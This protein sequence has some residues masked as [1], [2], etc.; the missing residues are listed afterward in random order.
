MTASRDGTTR[1]WKQTATVPPAYD[2][3]ESSHSATFKTCLAYAPPFKGYPDGLIISGGQDTLIEARQPGSTADQNADGLLV[4]HSNQVC[5][6]DVNAVAGWI[7]S[8][9]WDST[10]RIW[11]IN[12]WELDVELLGHRATVWAVVAY[13]NDMVVTG[14]ADHAIRVFDRRGKLFYNFNGKQVVRALVKL[15]KGHETGGELASASNDGHIRIW[16]LRGNQLAQLSGHESFIYSL[17][18]LPAGEIVSCGEDRSV[19]IWKGTDCAQVITLPAISIWSVSACPNGDIITGSSDKVARIFTR[20][21]S[22]LADASVISE[23]DAAVKSSVIPEQQL[24]EINKTDA[25]GPDFLQQK[26]GTK[27]GQTVMIKENDGSINAY[28]WSVSQQTW[29]LVGQVVS[30]SAAS[31]GQ[32][33]IYNGKEYDYVFNINISDERPDLK[34]PYNVTQNP[35]EVAMKFLTDNELPMTYLEETANFIVKNSEGATLGQAAQRHDTGPDPWGT[36]SRYRPGGGNVSSYQPPAPH[37]A[38]AKKLPQKEYVSI[39]GGKPEACHRQ[40][41]KLNEQYVAA[42]DPEFALLQSDLDTL[43]KLFQQFVGYRFDAAAAL[44]NAPSLQAGIPIAVRIATKWQPPS[45]RLAGIDLL[46]FLAATATQLPDVEA[47]GKDLVATIATSSIFETDTLASN[48]KLAM[49]AIRFF[50]NLFYGSAS[51]RRM[52]EA[53]YDLVIGKV[54][55]LSSSAASDV[56]LAVAVTTFWLNLAVYTTNRKAVSQQTSADRGLTI[57]EEL[58][59]VM[60]SLPAIEPNVSGSD[61]AQATEP[62]YRGLVA[63]GTVLVG[64]D[65][66]DVR[67]AAK[68]IFGIAALLDQLKD[69]GYVREPRF[70]APINETRAALA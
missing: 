30:S 3:T 58:A 54:K 20:E 45:N 43:S 36:E 10:A 68:E 29:H 15:P 61:L 33:T 17:T 25:P 57:V 62:A 38:P 22:R 52:L 40:I 67:M 16:T 46:R 32:K 39:V 65:D 26:S 8:G 23:F 64:L 55:L 27:E 63:L 34:L 14:C 56:T 42:D 28:Q 5:S 60:S 66:D 49:V 51:G 7:V 11:Q 6:L 47:E 70:Q 21:E 48:P 1:I 9:S 4:G 44:P 19:R 31:G 24:G 2:A 37:R 59:K 41:I 50:A 13:D 35:H 12:R 18:V 53:H 69:R